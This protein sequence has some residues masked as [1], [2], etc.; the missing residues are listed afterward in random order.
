MVTICLTTDRDKIMS[1]TIYHNQKCSKSRQTLELLRSRGVA[2]VIIEYLK[3]PPDRT[4][5][6]KL[7]RMLGLKP[8][9]LMRRQEKVYKEAGLDRDDLSEDALISA[10]IRH[11]ILIERPIVVTKGKAVIGRPP[12]NV[13]EIL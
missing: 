3:D 1:V 8:R 11:P 9:E 4:T 2:L 5:L 7:L 13:L 10:M 12:E 6:K